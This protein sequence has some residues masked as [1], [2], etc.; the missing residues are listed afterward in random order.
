[1]QP[2]SWARNRGPLER[3][4][5]LRQ[6]A[7]ALALCLA[8]AAASGAPVVSTW[9][10]GPALGGASCA[11]A[12]ALAGRYAVA[13]RVTD[14]VEI[15]DIRGNLL[16]TITRAEI[17]NLMPW[18][19]LTSAPDGPGALA[20][21]DSGRLLFIVV[22]DAAVPGDGQPGDAVLRY[23]ANTDSLSLHRRLE[24]GV[25]DEATPLGAAH[26]RGRL[27]VA[28]PLGI[29]TINAGRNTT[30]GSVLAT[31]TLPGGAAPR[32]LAIDRDGSNLFV[33]SDQTVFRAPT[34]SLSLPMTEVG[35][36][37]G[38]RALAFSPQ[39]GGVADD[40][41]L[42]LADDG[43]GS[44]L[45]RLSPDSARGIAPFSPSSYLSL[46]DSWTAL[47]ATADGA[48]LLG[49][50]ALGARRVTDDADARLGF[51]EW[52]LDELRQV[53]HFCKGLVSPDG[54]PHGWV[55]DADVQLGWSRFHPATPDGA[56][57]TILALLASDAIDNDP[58]AQALVGDILE[59]YAGFAPDG[60]GASASGSGILRHWIDPLTGQT[61]PGWSAEYALY[62]TMKLVA[63]AER[64]MAYYPNDLRIQQAGRSIVCSVTGWDAFI[65]PGTDA[66]YLT[67]TAGGSPASDPRNFPYTEGI[68]FVE[69]ASVFGG[70]PSDG[71]F[72]RWI[73]RSLWPVA[74]FINGQPITGA[75][76]GA[77]LPAFITAYSL[78]LQSDFRADADWLTHAGNLFASNGAWTDDNAPKYF[79]VFSAGTT[80]SEWGGYRADDLGSHPGDVTGFPSLM[81]FSATGDTSPAVAAYHAYRRGARQTFLT[82]ASILY[83]RSNVDQAYSPNSAGLPDVTHGALGLA[84]LIQPGFIDTVL[85]RPYSPYA[86][87][88]DVNESGATDLEDLYAW[89]AAPVDL[90][91]DAQVTDADRE[92]LQKYLRR[93][94]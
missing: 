66:V 21:S 19:D 52:L 78:L 35:P 42:V 62:S 92:Y 12:S 91:R 6:T 49:A 14:S 75:G 53:V 48:L 40:G 32:S 58:E 46:P 81:A 80:K 73:D 65:Q 77:Y 64:A 18:A 33:C 71:A 74:S 59:R 27:Y 69:Q 3:G 68:H 15:R 34:G 44:R 89:H 93:G 9:P 11:S 22:H 10:T 28:H 45:W 82:G 76:A 83:R 72:S 39:Y 36:V 43:A 23:D 57:W 2:V 51:E 30:S 61:K 86:C 25:G 24:M 56:C 37:A 87:P 67:S 17:A 60:I 50:D 55:I 31:A 47:A 13:D 29:S 8:P 4:P 88:P 20:W 79:T 84:E 70:P 54:E 41:L 94:E 5:R 16:R 85:A 1:M 26:F 90:D 63:A 38:A 7:S